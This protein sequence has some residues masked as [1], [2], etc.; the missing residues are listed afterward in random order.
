[1]TDTSENER[2][3]AAA[4]ILHDVAK[5]IKVL[6]ALAWPGDARETFLASG[7][8]RL[9]EVEYTGFDPGPALDG[10]AAARR[11][12]RGGT[13]VDEWLESESRSIESTALMMGSV[14]TQAFSVYSGQVYGVP[15]RPLRY[16]PTTPLELATQV[17]ETID[18]LKTVGLL[19]PPP[20]DRT[21]EE[22]AAVLAAA[23]AEHFGDDA[24]E[25]QVVDELSAN[26]A[27]SAS[28]IRVR[29]DARF[30]A[31]DAAQL[32]NHEAF[33]HVAT[34]LNGKAQHDLPILAVGHPGTT[35]TQEGLAVFS[36]FVSGSLDL[37]RLRRLA[38]RV[39]AVQLVID[40]A[41][42]M[43]LYRWF[44]ERAADEEQAFES[45][46]RIFRGAPLDGGAP[47]TKDCGYLSGLLGV[48][49]FVRAA[50]AAGRSDTLGLLFA[51]KLDLWA[52]PALSELRS[53]GLCRPA[54]FLP[55][56]ARDP[57]WV[58]TYLTLSTF[59][60]RIDLDAVTATVHDVLARCPEVRIEVPP[61]P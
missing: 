8:T 23:V 38:D 40:G 54:R 29:R 36:E 25:V 33:I 50:F 5:P 21:G 16:D 37:D 55:P 45:T 7:G 18:E 27:A 11:E 47:F 59:M 49:T 22:V 12:L 60:A 34:A 30:T 14:G 48:T 41:D 61:E 6:S 53:R 35:R 42:F 19:V 31:R 1:M 39:L 15:T 3:C 10:V 46:R 2:W 17:H 20:R 58:L 51:G 4:K 44:L 52:I 32:L 56:W 28:R 24:P 26:A 57:A 13:F 9:P 43:E